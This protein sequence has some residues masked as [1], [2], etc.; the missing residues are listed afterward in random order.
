MQDFV[1]HRIVVYAKDV[2]N[3]TGLSPRTAWNLL[4]KIRKHYNKQKGQYVT[5]DEFCQY[6]GINKEE[7]KIYLK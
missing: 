5:L 2:S 1:T 6:T 3:I 4:A 7:V